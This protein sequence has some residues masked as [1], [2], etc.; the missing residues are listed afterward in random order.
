MIASR[1]TS[2]SIPVKKSLDQLRSTDRRRSSKKTGKTTHF[3]VTWCRTPGSASSYFLDLHSP[4]VHFEYFN[5]HIIPSKHETPVDHLFQPCPKCTVPS[6][7]GA[8]LMRRRL[9]FCSMQT[10]QA[11]CGVTRWRQP[12]DLANRN[13]CLCKPQDA[14]SH[15]QIALNYNADFM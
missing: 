15:W 5:L 3:P 13:L 12:M 9:V 10:R 2:I 4:V 14:H 1:E 6:L 7:L 8:M 11:S